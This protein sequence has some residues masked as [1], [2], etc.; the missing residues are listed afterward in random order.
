MT[1]RASKVDANQSGIVKIMRGMGASVC[2]THTVGKGFPDL[3]VG[4]SGKTY[5]VEIK[6]GSLPPSARPLTDDQVEFHSEWRGH[7]EIVKTDD[8]A[9]SFM[10]RLI[11]NEIAS[12]GSGD[13]SS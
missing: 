6:D 8:E 1:R 13:R 3:V 9:I 2:P 7:V 11:R 4:Y 10:N 12:G 5:L